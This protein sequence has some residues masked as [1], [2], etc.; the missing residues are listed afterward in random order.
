[1]GAFRTV[2]G[3]NMDQYETG[4]F[5]PTRFLVLDT[6][7]NKSVQATSTIAQQPLQ[8]G[9]TMSDHMYRDPTTFSISG[10][11]SLNG[12]N[13]DDDSYDFIQMGDR[14]IEAFEARATHQGR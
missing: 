3:C 5:E 6:Q 2:I 4:S 12:K 1:M 9:D 11:F 7:E 13:W 8:S 10:M 14:L